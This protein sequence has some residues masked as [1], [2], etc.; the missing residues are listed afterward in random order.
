MKK[1]WATSG[2]DLHLELGRDQPGPGVRAGLETALREA[3]RTG[4]LGPGVRLPSSRALAADLGVARNTVAEAYGQLVAEGWLTAVQGSGTRVAGQAATSLAPAAHPAPAAGQARAAGQAPTGQA[5]TAGQAPVIGSPRA[6][7]SVPPRVTAYRYSLRVGSPDLSAFPRAAWLAAARRALSA[8]PSE[9]FGYG[10]P[11]GRPELRAAL[12]E[13]LARA[14]G[15]R[16]HPDRIVVCDGFGEGL[17]LLTRV[18]R[19]RGATTLA[20]EEYGLPSA[21]DTAVAA[22]LRLTTLPVDGH[23]AMASPAIPAGPAS[24][25]GAALLTPAHQF[26]LG[27]AL[28]PARRTQFVEWARDSGGLIIED[29]YDGEFRYDRQPV[30]ALQA[31]APDHV[32]Y[33]GSASKSLAPGFRLGWLVL[34]ASLVGEVTAARELATGP[35][36]RL[37]QLTLAEFITSGGYDRHIRRSRLAY[38]RRRDRLA[39]ALGREAPRVRVTGIAAGLHALCELPPGLTEDQVV[40]RAAARGLEVEGLARY[41]AT[42]SAANRA[43]DQAT[44]SATHQATGAGRGPSGRQALVIGYGSPPEHS[45]SGAVARLC[46]ALNDPA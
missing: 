21:R 24:P 33:A 39:A 18:L 19:A 14:R 41:R 5:P 15:V 27:A 10:Q 7:S 42:G 11:Q 17:A 25:A 37:D 4:R 35:G 30:G 23:G 28:A 29:D 12:A 3:V 34:P 44:G 26:P 9:A 2:L 20:V 43:T 40:A 36:S 45:F 31:L 1:D 32:A 13:Y 16:A 6:A 38:R 8:A 22:G 46:A